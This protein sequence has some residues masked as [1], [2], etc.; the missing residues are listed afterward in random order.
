VFARQRFAVQHARRNFH[1]ITGE[2]SSP[3]RLG[4]TTNAK[5]P[6]RIFELLEY[7][8]SDEGAFLSQ[9]GIEGVH[10]KY[11]DGVRT[12]IQE[13][14]DRAKDDPALENRTGIGI[15]ENFGMPLLYTY[16]A[17]GYPIFINR[18]DEYKARHADP[19]YLP[20]IIRAKYGWPTPN[21][22]VE[23]N[24]DIKY[25]IVPSGVAL[26]PGSEFDILRTRMFETRVHHIYD[27][28]TAKEGQFE[29]EFAKMLDEYYT[30]DVQSVYDEYARLT[31]EIIAA[32]QG[33]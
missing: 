21:K 17:D 15:F 13:F 1:V 14:F 16:A 23:D 22:W 10:W 19:N 2:H 27:I 25:T 11:V 18:S 29:A 24:T 20:N 4:V 5:H 6:G 28:W 7:L 30:I 33:K 31:D 32:V 8:R 9:N 12:E 26:E 3:L